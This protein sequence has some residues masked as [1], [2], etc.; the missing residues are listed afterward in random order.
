MRDT[1]T[2]ASLGAKKSKKKD[3]QGVEPFK[4]KKTEP[5]EKGEK[6]PKLDSSDSHRLSNR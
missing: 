5:E 4:C 2:L 1:G 3:E 6:L